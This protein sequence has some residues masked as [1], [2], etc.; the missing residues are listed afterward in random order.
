MSSENP[1]GVDVFIDTT[2]AAEK[3]ANGEAKIKPENLEKAQ[4][5]MELAGE[6]RAEFLAD[7]SLLQKTFEALKS[8]K[9]QDLGADFIPWLGGGKMI[10]D[11]LKGQTLISQEKL[12]TA[13]RFFYAGGGLA[14]E[15][16][17]T[18][19]VLDHLTDTHL[20]KYALMAKLPSIALTAL[21]YMPDKAALVTQLALLQDKL[22]PPT[23]M[24]VGSLSQLISHLNISNVDIDLFRSNMQ[25]HFR[26]LSINPEING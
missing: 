18:S 15:F 10:R 17:W 9:L 25:E 6:D 4:E 7:S 26:Q 14:T 8:P 5:V 19:L 23:S 22:T 20:T 12:S 11:A 2:P 21:S 1:F 3:P 24:L 16:I 13:K